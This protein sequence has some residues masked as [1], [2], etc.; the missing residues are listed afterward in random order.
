MTT[1]Y[2]SLSG[3]EALPGA[4][5]DGDGMSNLD[6]FAFMGNPTHGSDRGLTKALAI[7]TNSNGSKELNYTVAVRTGATFI[8]SPSPVATLDGVT[9]TIQ[10]ST[11]LTAFTASV[12]EVTPALTPAQTGLPVITGSGWDYHTFK[13]TSS[14]GLPGKGFLRAQAEAP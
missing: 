9:Y 11:N 8:G 2:P 7:D 1:S 5:P 14:E 4:D 3:D 13:L 10:G 6:E 12:T